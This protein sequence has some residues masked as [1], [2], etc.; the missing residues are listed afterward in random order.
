MGIDRLNRLAA[1]WDDITRSAKEATH[2]DNELIAELG[3]L[4]ELGPEE[5][6]RRALA[7]PNFYARLNQISTALN[8]INPTT[9]E[10]DVAALE[11]DD[12]NNGDY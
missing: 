12:N 3:F 4:A 10:D 11:G 8:M 1:E 2:V 5:L 6:E 9:P 7:D